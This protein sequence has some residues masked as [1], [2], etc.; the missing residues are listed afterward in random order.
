MERVVKTAVAAMTGVSSAQSSTGSVRKVA[1]V[2]GSSPA[3]KIF[4]ESQARLTQ[5]LKPAP[6]TM[7]EAVPRDELTRL[8]PYE[9]PPALRQVPPPTQPALT[10][11]A[12]CQQTRALSLA[13]PS[14]RQIGRAHV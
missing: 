8:S 14:P 12:L 5:G 7:E 13:G 6:S 2:M 4:D 11:E 9:V 3:F 10:E 1:G